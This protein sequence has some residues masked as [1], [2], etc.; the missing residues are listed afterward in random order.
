[1]VPS[2]KNSTITALLKHGGISVT[3]HAAESGVVTIDWYSGGNGAIVARAKAKRPK[4]HAVLVAAGRA[5]AGGAGSVTVKITL[6]SAGRKL[7]QHTRSLK[8]TGEGGFK[9]SGGAEVSSS[10][11]FELYAARTASAA[12]ARLAQAALADG[13][14]STTGSLAQLWLD[15]PL[16]S[17]T[18]TVLDLPAA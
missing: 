13:A 4:A 6:T 18:R 2:G 12:S 10:K 5:T 14:A 8:L 1:L 11:S 9:P 15:S 3:L 17:W 16:P 7:L